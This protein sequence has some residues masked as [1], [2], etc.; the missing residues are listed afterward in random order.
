MRSIK[1]AIKMSSV[2]VS[3]VA[4]VDIEADIFSMEFFSKVHFFKRGS[5]VVCSLSVCLRLWALIIFL[6]YFL[7][8]FFQMY[9]NGYFFKFILTVI[10]Q[11]YFDGYFFKLILTS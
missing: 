6:I 9:F 4:H 7:R 5:W 8:L 11:I 2:S 3:H 10:F 1:V